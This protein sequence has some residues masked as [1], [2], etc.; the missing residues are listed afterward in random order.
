MRRVLGFL[1]IGFMLVGLAACNTPGC[2]VQQKAADVAGNFTGS[3]LECEDVAGL[4]KMFNDDVL[5]HTGLCKAAESGVPQGTLADT[6][7][8][9][10][11]NTVVDFVKAQ[12]QPFLDKYK[13]KATNASTFTKEK[14]E[15]LC[16]TIPL[17]DK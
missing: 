8:P 4:R 14:L 5:S 17:S 7:C 3:V 10:V 9:I 12:G 15:A 13:C 11:A 16:K 1:M 6:F 2:L